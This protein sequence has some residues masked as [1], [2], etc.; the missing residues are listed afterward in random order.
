[1]RSRNLNRYSPDRFPDNVFGKDTR[2]SLEGEMKAC[3]AK[4]QMTV[5]DG[6]LHSYCEIESDVPGIACYD[7]GAARQCFTMIDDFSTAAF[8]GKL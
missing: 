7:P 4:W 2:E 1:M 6:L 3:G 5:F 8:E